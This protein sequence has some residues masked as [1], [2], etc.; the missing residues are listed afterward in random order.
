[1]S[2]LAR[3]VRPAVGAV[4]LTM[5]LLAGCGVGGVDEQ[6]TS[7]PALPAGAALNLAGTCPNKIVIQPGWY[8]TADVAL[9]FQ[10]LAGDYRIDA[11]RKRVSGSLVVGGRDTGIDLEYRSGGPAVGFQNG[12]ALAYADPAITMVFTNIDEMIATAGTAPMQAVIAP[13]N[14]DPQAVIYDPATYPDVYN[15]PDFKRTSTKILYSGNAQAAFGYLA[16]TGILSGRQLDGSY[17]GSPSQFV[18]ARG[19]VA[20][21]GYATNEVFVYENLPQWGRPVAYKLIQ[22]SGYPNYAGVLA[23]RPRDKAS[24][25]PCLRKLVPIL[26]QAQIELWKNPAPAARRLVKSVT[27]FNT[28]FI[29]ADGNAQFGFCQLQREGLVSNPRSGPIG[30]LEPGKVQRVLDILRPVLAGKTASD[31]P[32]LK[33]VDVP[34]GLTGGSLA[35]NEFLDPA[36]RLPLAETAYYAGCKERKST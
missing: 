15:L 29:Y 13:L 28:S 27:D 32:G 9:P 33:G 31:L 18:A 17:D 12:P 21:Q 11:A 19:E 3:R 1:M 25:T 23:I 4:V 10:L 6:G 35:T 5:F 8:P 24:L 36:L 2:T 20:V 26:Q 34:D 30:T 22:D 16:G 7:A 14:G